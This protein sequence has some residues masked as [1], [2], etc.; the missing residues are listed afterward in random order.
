[1]NTLRIEKSL[2]APHVSIGQD[3]SGNLVITFDEQPITNQPPFEFITQP[4]PQ[5]IPFPEELEPPV[6]VNPQLKPMKVRKGSCVEKVTDFMMAHPD[7]GFSL[8]ELVAIASQV[9]ETAVFTG[10]KRLV[11]QGHIEKYK[12]VAGNGRKSKLYRMSI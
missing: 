7:E 4:E 8:A 3:E 11:E 9:S 1:M 2:R 10:L 5:G 12:G 6:E